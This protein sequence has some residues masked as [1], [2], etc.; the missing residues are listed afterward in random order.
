MGEKKQGSE[1]IRE[2]FT[3]RNKSNSLQVSE[4]T[5]SKRTPLED[6]RIV[7]NPVVHLRQQ[8]LCHGVKRHGPDSTPTREIPNSKVASRLRLIE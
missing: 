1:L 7:Q 6:D 2:S 8:D 5:P 4:G 3:Q